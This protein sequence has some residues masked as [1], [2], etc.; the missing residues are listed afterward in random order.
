MP[1]HGS[2]ESRTSV[3][4][5]TP[6]VGVPPVSFRRSPPKSPGRRLV[7]PAAPAGCRHAP[8]GQRDP[9]RA[10]WQ[11]KGSYQCDRAGC[12][13]RRAG[14]RGL[15][16]KGFRMPGRLRF[17]G[18]CVHPAMRGRG[19]GRHREFS[20]RTRGVP[21]SPASRPALRR[22]GAALKRLPTP[23]TSARPVGVPQNLPQNLW[24]N[25]PS[26]PPVARA[27]GVPAN[28][29]NDIRPDLGGR[30]ASPPPPAVT[31]TN[32]SASVK[33][34]RGHQ[35]GSPYRRACPP[36]R[37]WAL[38]RPAAWVSF[39]VPPQEVSSCGCPCRRP[40]GTERRAVGV[41]GN[42]P[43][44]TSGKRGSRACPPPGV[45]RWGCGRTGPDAG[46][47]RGPRRPVHM[48]G[49]LRQTRRGGSRTDT[50][51]SRPA[52]PVSCS[53]QGAT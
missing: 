17:R 49:A 46:R 4:A 2:G 51:E 21:P 48:R 34:Q 9:A 32:S 25:L 50:A 12:P 26:G 31:G 53:S 35:P 3:G 15:P 10:A 41:P 24:A 19:L 11:D 6:S 27:M 44:E 45:P 36:A 40:R 33:G 47:E 29:P 18:L 52:H 22:Q 1:S 28:L 7:T 16:T 42:I 39:R 5:T 14:R 8:R 20:R 43:R 38:T 23:Q 37:S 13:G 30:R